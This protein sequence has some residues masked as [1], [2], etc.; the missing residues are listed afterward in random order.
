VGEVTGTRVAASEGY[1]TSP[2]IVAAA[3]LGINA[4]M[5]TPVGPDAVRDGIGLALSGGGFRV[6]LF[7]V[8][9]LWRLNELGVLRQLSRISS[10]S[11]GSITS[12]RLAMVWTRLD[13]RDGVARRFDEEVVRPLRDFTSRTIDWRAVI[14]GVL[15]PRS[16]AETLANLYDRYLFG[17]T[18]LQDLADDAPGTVPQFVFNASNLQSGS[19][20][21]FSKAYAADYQVGVIP[22]PRLRLATAVA[23]S[24]AFPPMLSP[25]ALNVRPGDFLP[26]SGMSLEM[27]PYTSRVVLT[28][29]GVYDNLG[30]ETI[31]KR[32][33][34]VLV[35]DAGA[36][37]NPQPAPKT[38]WIRMMV[39]VMELMDN[40]VR[41]VRVRQMMAAF[42]A[43]NAD[44]EVSRDGA[45]WAIHVDI[46]RYGLSDALACPYASTVALAQMPTRLAALP[47]VTQERLINWGYAVCDAAIRRYYVPGTLAPREFP[48]PRAG[49]G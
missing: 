5:D 49:V 43:P 15:S 9:A 27:P 26:G 40:Q 10:V 23:A 4:S 44:A 17:G 48:Y 35:S 34:T 32:F 37:L 24:S 46:A 16:I 47:A 1:E 21:R 33:R 13:F 2:L 28:D 36:A 42:E 31:W 12:G 3:P 25:L 29:G 22:N 41:A 20:W 45:F 30:V 11:G 39:R 38:D 7:H 18:S 14:Y 6:A 19:L 8:G